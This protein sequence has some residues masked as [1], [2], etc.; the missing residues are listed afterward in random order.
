MT[1]NAHQRRTRYHA[2]W[3][4]A[5]GLGLATIAACGDREPTGRDARL[6]K[7]EFV[8][9]IVA[10]RTAEQE[11]ERSMPTDSVEIEFARQKA[12]ILE[13]YGA[14][15][16]DVRAFV[17]RHHARPGFMAEVWDTIA[18]RLRAQPPDPT[19]DPAP[20]EEFW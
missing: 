4:I 8:E 5:T 1:N 2:P 10:L 15:D 17:E 13:R 9:I 11:A 6:G 19:A 12:A 7:T 16:D 20:V 3:V 14:T 18:Q